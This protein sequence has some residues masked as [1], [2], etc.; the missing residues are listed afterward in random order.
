LV[1]DTSAL[2]AGILHEA[3][4]EELLRIISSAD[5]KMAAPNLLEA[6]LVMFSRLGSAGSEL[7]NDAVQRL[8]IKVVPFTEAHAFLAARANEE[9]GKGRHPAKLNF[10]DCIAYSVAK[11]TGEPLLYI[12]SD[13]RQ[14]DVLSVL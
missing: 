6:H 8:R 13:F 9:F 1:V 2:L 5:S 3:G 7:V 14:T 12:G 11:A 4:S 10:G